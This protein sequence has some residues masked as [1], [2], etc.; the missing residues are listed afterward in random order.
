VK[1]VINSSLLILIN[2]S[3]GAV[4]Y[5]VP[6]F[7]YSLLHQYCMLIFCLKNLIGFSWKSRKVLTE[8]F[9]KSWHF[10]SKFG[11][12]LTENLGKSWKFSWNYSEK[13]GKSWHFPENFGMSYLKNWGSLSENSWKISW[14]S[15]EKLGKFLPE[16]FDNLI[17]KI[18][19]SSLKIVLRIIHR[20]N[21]SVCQP[22]SDIVSYGTSLR[23]GN[24]LSKK[25]ISAY[26]TLVIIVYNII[27]YQMLPK[28]LYIISFIMLIITLF[29]TAIRYIVMG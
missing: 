29:R 28:A 5:T 20:I 27:C 9:G 26:N 23:R 16:N 25:S 11:E 24:F 12:V 18:S 22:D 14:E 3:L 2:F 6:I 17:L 4:L 15:I 13:L 7:L 10:L 21:I 8:I 1:R 19:E